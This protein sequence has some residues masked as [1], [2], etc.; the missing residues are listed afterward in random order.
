[1]E[2]VNE[3]VLVRR[4]ETAAPRTIFLLGQDGKPRKKVGV[5]IGGPFAI[6]Q[7]IA[8]CSEELK[9]AQYTCG[10][11]ANL[12]EVLERFVISVDVEMEAPQLPTDA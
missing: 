9:P 2:S 11:F 1:M 12:G 6:F 5:T 4:G 3:I 10:V 8:V 7:S